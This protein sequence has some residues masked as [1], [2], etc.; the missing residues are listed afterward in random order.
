MVG[1]RDDRD[2]PALPAPGF[3]ARPSLEG[4]PRGRAGGRRQR[5]QHR[6][7]QAAG[8]RAGRVDR[9]LRR[10]LQRL[11]ADLRLARTS[12]CSTVSFTV[13]A[14]VVLGGMGNIWGVAVGAFI[15]YMIQQRPPE[16]AQ[17]S[18]ST[19]ARRS[20]SSSEHRL[21]RSTSSCSTAWPSCCMMLFRPEGLFPSQRRR[22]SCTSRRSSTRTFGDDAGGQRPMGESPGAD[23]HRSARTRPSD[24]P[25]RDR[26]RADEGPAARHGVTKRFGGLVAVND[27]RLRRSPKGRSSASSARTAPARRR[28]S[29]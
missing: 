16:A 4:H 28:S 27:D 2:D 26:D 14:M 29:T 20:R 11:E 21:H 5:H 22:R 23:G 19:G 12:S 7:D 3:P 18:S 8:V 6:H 9:R 10:R 15:I 25:G 1:H 17:H 13:L 24:A